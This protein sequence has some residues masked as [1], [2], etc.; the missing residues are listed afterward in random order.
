ML[1][2]GWRKILVRSGEGLLAILLVL[3]FSLMLLGILNALFPSGT[4]LRAILAGQK[5]SESTG[6]SEG[7]RSK[8]LVVRGEQES[9]LAPHENWA[10]QL[11]QI[12]NT[13]KSKRA[14]A[15]AW[16]TAKEG[17]FLYDRDA[18]QTLNRS[19]A[20]IE[21]DEDTTLDM[22]EN[23]LVI[24]KRLAQD[25]LFNE[26]RSFTV[27]V[28]G[29]L[30]G[31]LAESEQRSVHLEIDTPGAKVR[32]QSELVAQGPVD[33][34]V[35]VNPDKSSTIAVYEGSA[36]ISAEGK[37][38]ILGANQ[39]TEVPLKHAPLPTRPLPEPVKLKSPPGSSFYYYRDH[40]SKIR[41]AWQS[42][43]GATS[44]HFVLARDASFHDM[45]TD[46]RLSTTSLTHSNL[47]KATYFWKVS[48]LEKSV[49][50]FF[51]ETRRFQVV[52]DQEP[53]TLQVQFP[54]E[55][56]NSE[57]YTLRGKAEPGARV[58]VGGN[59]VKTTRTGR[60]QYKLKL[61]LGINTIVVE[62]IDAMNNVAYRSQRVKR[63]T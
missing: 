30:R 14:E 10:A 31:K 1:V 27:L 45:V 35:S 63:K 58:F 50:G 53:P 25:P 34:K 52:Q 46:K 48:A 44:Y 47:K 16:R 4:S 33:F 18:V 61:R 2:K 49:E 40:P 9:D 17:K 59:R 7:G 32:T 15:I 41:F 39:A 56:V 36:E 54:P 8:L 19:A 26:K 55:T 37:K 57:S 28:D 24:I 20:L 12:R 22:G 5:V 6:L 11:S 51:S 60:F 29:E 43:P 23:T 3:V 13:V 21:F 42:L 62:A 38:V